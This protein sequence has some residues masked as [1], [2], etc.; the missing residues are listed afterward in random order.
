M[1][2]TRLTFMWLELYLMK[3]GPLNIP[4]LSISGPVTATLLEMNALYCGGHQFQRIY[5]SFIYLL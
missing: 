4:L 1:N 2:M 3:L 5:I